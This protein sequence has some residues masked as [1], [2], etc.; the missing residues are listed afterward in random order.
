[1]ERLVSKKMRFGRRCARCKAYFV[2]NDETNYVCPWC[3]RVEAGKMKDK[4]Y[5]TDDF[6]EL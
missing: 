4:V 2:T 1:M 3:Q 5:V 6:I